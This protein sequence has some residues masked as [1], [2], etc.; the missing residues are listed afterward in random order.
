MSS[1]NA[2]EVTSVWTLV[3]AVPGELSLA[4][5]KK[6][7]WQREDDIVVEYRILDPAHPAPLPV[8]EHPST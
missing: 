4:A 2:E 7:I 6:F 3:Q 1:G 5:L 8:V